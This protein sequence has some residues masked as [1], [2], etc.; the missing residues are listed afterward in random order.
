MEV[1]SASGSGIRGQ[2]LELIYGAGG[3]G[4]PRRDSVV[5]TQ[6]RADDPARSHLDEASTTNQDSPI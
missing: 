6:M 1:D 4:P 2:A 5:L 3:V